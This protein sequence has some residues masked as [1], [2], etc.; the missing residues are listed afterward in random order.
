MELYW[1]RRNK[2]ERQLVYGGCEFPRT[3]MSN[4]IGFKRGVD[5]LVGCCILVG[6]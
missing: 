3:P 2:F 5:V 4:L 1:L 6:L